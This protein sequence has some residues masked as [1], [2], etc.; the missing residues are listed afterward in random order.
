MTN[1]TFSLLI[2]YTN[3]NG[4]FHTASKSLYAFT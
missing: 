3:I 4:F 2:W 1:F